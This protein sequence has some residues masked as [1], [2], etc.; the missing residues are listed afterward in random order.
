[1]GYWQTVRMLE[2]ARDSDLFRPIVLSED[3]RLLR[4]L[5]NTVRDSI[6]SC[7]RIPASAIYPKQYRRTMKEHP[8]EEGACQQRH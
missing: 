4:E 8:I 3:D 7:H 1:M 2:E 5:M 6:V